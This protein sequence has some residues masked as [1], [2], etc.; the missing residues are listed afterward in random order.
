M[1]VL[2]NLTIK[3]FRKSDNKDMINHHYMVDVLL[4]NKVIT[5]FH[6]NPMVKIFGSKL[7]FK[8]TEPVTH[9]NQYYGVKMYDAKLYFILEVLKYF[10]SKFHR[11]WPIEK[12]EEWVNPFRWHGNTK[13]V[14]IIQQDLDASIEHVLTTNK[15]LA[16]ILMPDLKDVEYSLVS[17]AECFESSSDFDDFCDNFSYSNDSRKAERI[18]NACRK[19]WSILVKTGKYEEM[20]ETYQD[21]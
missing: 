14:D 1:C 16:E 11:D 10:R 19:I 4:D 5:Q 18:Y 15:N 13:L 21:Y 8:S 9:G 2:K 12:I 3:N 20:K 7:K 17:D 6:Y